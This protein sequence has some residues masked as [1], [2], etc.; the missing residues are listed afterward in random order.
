MTA[1][2]RGTAKILHRGIFIERQLQGGDGSHRFICHTGIVRFLPGLYE[3]Q[4]AAIAAVDAALAAQ[5]APGEI[6]PHLY[7]PDYQAMGDCRTCGHE[8]N[9]PW[10][11]YAAP[12]EPV[13]ESQA[14]RSDKVCTC[15]VMCQ[16]HGLDGGCR[17]LR[18]ERYTLRKLVD[19]V[20][21]HATKSTTVPA[22]HTADLLIDKVFT[23]PR[24]L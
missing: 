3:T 24:L 7:M 20:Y 11:I 23:L 5:A 22:T 14:P 17:Y 9:K 21:Q 2:S 4:E 18:P 10:H 6:K 19:I 12:G 15:G 13:G 1:Q 8:Q 16:D